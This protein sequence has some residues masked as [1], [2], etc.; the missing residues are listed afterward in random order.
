MKD[1]NQSPFLTFLKKVQ[2]LGETRWFIQLLPL[3][4][5]CLLFAFFAIATNGRFSEWKS[6]KIILD[7][8]LIVGTVAT[9]AA[10]IFASGNV[11]LA[12]G[13]TTVLAATIA[14]M[15]FNATG[16]VVVMIVVALAMSI[17]LMVFSALLS[18]WLNV[19][20]MYVTIVMM[21]L[22]AA[23]QQSILGGATISLPYEMITMLAT[24]GIHYIAFA[25]F[26]LLSVVLFH[27]TDIGRSLK[28]IGTN[29]KCA[30]QTGIEK[31]KYLLIAFIIAGV[32]CGIGS[33]LAIVRAGS[34]GQNTLASLNMDCMLALVLGGMSIFGGSKSYVYAGIVGSI[35][36]VVLSQGLLMIG[37]DSTIIQGVRGVVFLLLVCTAQ[38]RPQGL[39]TPEG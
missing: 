10:F 31:S 33:L 36:V 16:S 28:M 34:I 38:Q 6:V 5:L 19:K 15:V 20:V 4:F 7:Q 26:F 23:I 30:A 3:I 11:N 17:A 8:A 14:G 18:T 1:N 22:F 13:A 35:T 9:G 32:G 2:K 39:P 27:F 29:E 25:L 12:M 37:V 21:S 24:N